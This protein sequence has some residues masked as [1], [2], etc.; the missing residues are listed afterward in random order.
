MI[1]VVVNNDC[2]VV[3]SN[4][5]EGPIFSVHTNIKVFNTIT[6]EANLLD[7]QLEFLQ[8]QTVQWSMLKLN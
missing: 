8:A 2:I 7:L 6:I 3:G 5:M 1:S 4:G